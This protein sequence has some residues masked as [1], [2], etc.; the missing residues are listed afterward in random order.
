MVVNNSSFRFAPTTP[1][2]KR[3]GSDCITTH[4][5]D[6]KS[7]HQDGTATMTKKENAVKPPAEGLASQN[8]MQTSMQ[9]KLPE[10]P[11]VDSFQ[12]TSGANT[13]STPGTSQVERAAFT[14]EKVA[15]PRH[16]PST[17]PRYSRRVP[18][19]CESCRQRKTKC[20]GD[21]PHGVERFPPNS[22]TL[23]G[24]L[25]DEPSSPS[26][27]GSLDGIDRV[28]EDLNRNEESRAAG[29][30]GKIS[31][32]TWMQHLQ[33]KAKHCSQGSSGSLEHGQ[34]KSHED[35]P[36]LHA[37]NYHSDE[38]DI[39]C[40]EPVEVYAVPPP[41]LADR[42]FDDY[43]KTVHPFF[44]IINRRLFTAQYR[45]FFD[46]NAQPSDKWLAIM[47]MIF[48]IG[49]QY[50]H[51]TRAPWRGEVG[52]HL[53]YLTRARILSVNGDDLFSH[54]DLQQIQVEG[55][56]AFYLLSTDQINR[57]W[58]ISALAVRSAITLGLNLKNNSPTTPDVAKEA[59][60]RVWWCLYTLEHLLGTMTGRATY[61]VGVNLTTPLP[62]PFDEDQL[63]E[64]MAAE[65]FR[66]T[67]LRDERINNVMASTSV[68]HMPLHPTRGAETTHSASIYDN[69]W[70]KSLPFS[71][72]LGHL[73]YC[74]LALIVQEIVNKVYS[75]DCVML[76]WA[77]ILQRIGE[78]KVQ[79][80]QWYQCLPE[81]LNL[82]ENKD[83][84]SDPLRCKLALNLHYLSARITL[85]RPCFCRRDPQKRKIDEKSTFNH[86]MAELTLQ[87]AKLMLDLIPDE[88]NVI[89]LYEISPW[90]CIL[91]YLMQ[92]ATVIL[93]ELS[94]GSL[95]MPEHVTSSVVYSKKSLRWLYAM[96]AHSIAS[97]RAWQLCDISLR[98]LAVNIG[99]NV[100]DMPSA[101]YY[102]SVP[103]SA[104]ANPHSHM[105]PKGSRPGSTERWNS[106]LEDV[107][108]A[109]VQHPTQY[110]YWDYSNVPTTDPTPSVMVKSHESDE[111]YSPYDPISGAFIRSF[112][113]QLSE[114][115]QP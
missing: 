99:F 33:K 89:E 2:E 108:Q 39:S 54:P 102:Q 25:S 22:V 90:W 73:Y 11:S 86:D 58:R 88:P 114:D 113:P 59:R 69:S 78:L 34:S 104:L 110:P 10:A 46:S 31:E 9:N 68:R 28:E 72:S 37:T 98:A 80:D 77:H 97:R 42:L 32:V 83:N 41:Q 111:H 92:A 79:L 48:A 3:T 56:V 67:H 6:D 64:P 4:P 105:A 76:P 70:V 17:A 5:F 82:S 107:S 106:V 94:F 66:D 63:S 49:A 19:A 47:N 13:A 35:E 109:I 75:T 62:F 30:M 20:S 40:P 18:R 115:D 7:N 87:S 96:S 112:F 44:P 74:D 57:A 16:R 103:T 14:N 101:P 27:I 84:G 45:T 93:L 65:T 53:I 12:T 36:A 81:H 38:V 50:A 29:F 23:P 26:S 24:E 43:L 85:G 60:Y 51:L 1:G 8:S 100:D 52:D 15:I 21:I 55:L 95:M 61:I 71:F 91:H